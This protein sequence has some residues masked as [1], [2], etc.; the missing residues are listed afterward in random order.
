MDVLDL[1]CDGLSNAAIAERLRLTEKT[2]KNHL[3]HVFAKLER[4]QPHRG[5]AAVERWDF[6]LMT[7]GAGRP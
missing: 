7:A 2:V 1:L 5:G 3:Y 4:R 6:R